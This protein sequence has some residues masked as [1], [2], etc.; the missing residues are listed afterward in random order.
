MEYADR[1]VFCVHQGEFAAATNFLSTCKNLKII[2]ITIAS[3]DSVQLVDTRR[4]I[5][6][7]DVPDPVARATY[8]IREGEVEFLDWFIGNIQKEL[9][10]TVDLVIDVNDYWNPAV[11]IPVLNKYFADRNINASNWEELYHVWLTNSIDVCKK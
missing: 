4:K 8:C 7:K 3:D 1:Y 5:L 6:G 10:C 9:D 2:I 11:G